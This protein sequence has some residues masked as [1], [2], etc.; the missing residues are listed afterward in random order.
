MTPPTKDVAAELYDRLR[1]EIDAHPYR[2]VAIAAG[3]GYLL[4]TRLGG[5]L[6]ALLSSRVGLQLAST[7]VAPLLD[8][9]PNPPRP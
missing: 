7:L 1:R 9:D 3:V 8:P 5:S 6:F 2:T 4:G